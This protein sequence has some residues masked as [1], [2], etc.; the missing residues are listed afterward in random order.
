MNQMLLERVRATTESTET[1]REIECRRREAR[2]LLRSLLRARSECDRHLAQ[3]KRTDA[4][5]AV[6]GHSALDHAI[7]STRAMIDSL[8]CALDHAG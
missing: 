7:E 8:D 2:A 3:F 6:R 5:Q 4:M 1:D